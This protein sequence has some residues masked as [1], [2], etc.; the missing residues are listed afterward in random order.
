MRYTEWDVS[1]VS[2]KRDI[3]VDIYEPNQTTERNE[4]TQQTS[5]RSFTHSNVLKRSSNKRDVTLSEQEIERETDIAFVAFDCLHFQQRWRGGRN[6]IFEF[7]FFFKR[8]NK[9]KT[10]HNDAHIVF[11]RHTNHIIFVFE[12]LSVVWMPDSV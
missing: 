2:A 1:I 4:S 9:R 6:A 10:N 8:T 5:R 7:N 3:R 12:S 11:A